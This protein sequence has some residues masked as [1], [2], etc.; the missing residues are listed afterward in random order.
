MAVRLRALDE[1]AVSQP[2]AP[3]KWSRKEILGHLVDSATNSLHRF[4]RAREGDALTCPKYEQDHWVRVQHYRESAWPELID[5][6]MLLN[7]HLAQVITQIP[8]EK[9]GMICT[10][11]PY[12]PCTLQY[13]IDDYVVHMKHH[14]RQIGVA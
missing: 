13:L 11:G 4:V 1:P 10:I 5:L 8:D 7:R 12:D 6:W 3:G 9:L 2:R 14:L